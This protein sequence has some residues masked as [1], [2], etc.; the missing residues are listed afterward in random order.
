M[1]YTPLTNEALRLAYAAIT[2]RRIKAASHPC[3]L[4]EQMTDGV[5]GSKES[6]GRRLCAGGG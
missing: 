1:I 6:R 5:S 4:A 2:G 3:H